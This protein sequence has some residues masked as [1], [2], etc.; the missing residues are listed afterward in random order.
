L[1][2]RSGSGTGSTFFLINVKNCFCGD[3]AG[4]GGALAAMNN[5]EYKLFNTF[6]LNN[7]QKNVVPVYKLVDSIT[8]F[9]GWYNVSSS[10]LLLLY[11]VDGKAV[12][13]E[14]R[15]QGNK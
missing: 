4:N 8:K 14:A 15:R 5:P 3:R 13:E 6:V 2:K 12:S 10:L 11:Q 7:H 9:L 1:A